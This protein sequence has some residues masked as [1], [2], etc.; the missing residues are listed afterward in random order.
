[1]G[2]PVRTSPRRT[3]PVASSGA[4]ATRRRALDDLSRNAIIT[5]NAGGVIQ[6]ASDSVEHVFGWTPTE[7][8]GRNVKILIP[9]PRRSALDR[10][11]DRYRNADPAKTVKRTRRFDAVR[12]DGEEFHIELSVSCADIPSHSSPYFVGLIRDVSHEID[13]SADTVLERSRLQH[14]ITEQTR[15]LATAHLR[16]HLSDRLASLGTLA[17]GLGHDMNGVLLPVR[18]RLDALEHSGITHAAKGHLSAVR[19]SIAYLQHLSDGLQFLAIDPEDSGVAQS[20]ELPTDLA[21]WWGQVGPLLRKAL[22][23]HVK[24]RVSIPVGIPAVT[25]GPHWLTQAALNLIVNAGEAIPEGRRGGSVRIRAQAQGDGRTVTLSVTDNGRGMAPAIARRAFDLFFT[26]KSRSM[27]TGLGLPLVR[28]V[29]LRAGGDIQLTSEPG[30]GT[31]VVLTLP[32]APRGATPGAG[33]K[34]GTFSAAISVRNQRSAALIAQVLLAAGIEVTPAKGSGPG[35]AN[36]WITE[37]TAAALTAARRR[38]KRATAA[39]GKLSVVLLGSPPKLTRMR[40]AEIGVTI[41]ELPAQFEPVRHALGEAIARLR[42][43]RHTMNGAGT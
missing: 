14:L 3:A 39:S 19:Q 16:L 13:V 5:M 4:R 18:A 36:L 2:M 7:L 24:L 10:Y 38:T 30:K 37:P 27:G 40:W 8:M 34:S 35:G 31:A 21:R 26:T 12:K 6:S 20:D 41:I 33:S 1:M 9:E 23:G 32:A 42:G 22:P 11:L 29:A 43:K 15:A 25:I 17:A 28:K